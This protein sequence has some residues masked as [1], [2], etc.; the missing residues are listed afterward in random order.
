M[1]VIDKLATTLGRKNEVPNQ[2]LAEQIVSAKDREAVEELVEN[3]FNRDRRIQS[4]CIK[5]LYEIGAANPDLIAE[6]LLGFGGL[7]RSKHNRLVWGAMTALDYITLNEPQGVYK[8]MP[9]I[10]VAAEAGSVIA[11]DHAI[12]I[13]AKLGSL[14]QFS[15]KCVPLLIEQLK[16][17]PENQF[18]MYAEM[19][20]KAVNK[21]NMGLFHE[22]IG[23]RHATL[24]KE[25]QKKRITRVLRQLESG[26]G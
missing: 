19:S 17:C 15:E 24:A 7:L 26:T 21:K 6:H 8:L 12:G 2:I 23:N 3:L 16:T 11:R 1:T 13:L 22:A 9:E 10:Q 20:L 14:Q 4:D 18:P 25:S 5:V